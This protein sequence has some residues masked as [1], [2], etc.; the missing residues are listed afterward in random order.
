VLVADAA[1]ARAILGWT[2]RFSLDDIVTDAWRWHRV[3]HSAKTTSASKGSS[4]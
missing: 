3:Q 2:P 1:K 4:H